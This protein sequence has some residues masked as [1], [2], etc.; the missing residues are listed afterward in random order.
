MSHEVLVGEVANA[1]VLRTMPTSQNRDMGHPNRFSSVSCCMW[2]ILI[3]DVI[4]FIEGAV[5]VEGFAGAF[6]EKNFVVAEEMVDFVA[7]FDGDEE[8][9]AVAFAP[10]G[11]EILRGEEDR[12][13]VGEGA[14]EEHGR[15]AAVDQRDVVTE[16]EGDGGGVSLIAVE[17]NFVLTR[18][19]VSGFELLDGAGEVF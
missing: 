8:D 11:E 12:W 6:F 10:G 7:F 14:A 2:K 17:E 1:V 19:G 15:R 9:L 5:G 18:D 4:A 16:V 3:Y 13:G